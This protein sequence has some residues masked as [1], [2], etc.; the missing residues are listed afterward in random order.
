MKVRSLFVNLTSDNP[1]RLGAFYRDVVGLEQDPDSGEWSFHA[2]EG[3]T[4]GIDGHSETKGS[5]KEPSRVLIDLMVDDIAAAEDE[6]KGRGVSF[7]RSQGK[8]LWGG[9]ISTFEDPDGNYVQIIQY[10]PA[11]ATEQPEAAATA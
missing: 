9:I 2:G 4:I 11:A 10:D 5:A 7:L 1:Q 3:A 6:L 8:E